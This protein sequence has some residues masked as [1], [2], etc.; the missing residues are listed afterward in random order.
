VSSARRSPLLPD[1]PTM[2]E[3]G[4]PGF[5]LGGFLGLLAPRNTPQAIIK[6]LNGEVLAMARQRDFI[7]R[8]DTFGMQPVGSTPE[9]FEKFMIDQIAKWAAVFK[10][11][12][13]GQ[14]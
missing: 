4:L 7:E 3:S 1:L 11:A 13:A 8:L 12:K 5:E 2:Q 6:K 9:A 14:K 10:S